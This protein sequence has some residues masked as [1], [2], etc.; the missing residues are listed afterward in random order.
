MAH[1]GIVDYEKFYR[2]NKPAYRSSAGDLINFSYDSAPIDDSKKLD[3]FGMGDLRLYF[4]DNNA[5]NYSVQE[6]YVRY[7]GG[8]YKL[9][10]GRKILD[11]NENEKYW[12]LGYLNGNQAFTLLSNEEE[13][14]TGIL[15]NTEFKPFE[16]DFLFSYTFIPQLNPSIDFQKG[17]VRSKS[18]WVRLPPQKTII[19]GTEVPIYYKVKNYNIAKI[20]FNKSLGGNLRY[21]WGKGGVSAFA[22]YKPENRLRANAEAYY[23]NIVLNKVVVEADPT[24]N[25]HAYYGIQV[26]QA[27]GDLK[28]KAGLS[29]VD[30]NAHIGKD[31]PIDIT[32]AR[33]TFKSPYFSINP[34]YEKEAYS[35]FSAN[36]GRN[37]YILSLNYI[38]II[39]KNIRTNDDF[40]S[41]TVK[42]KRAFGGGF[43]YFITDSFSVLF[44]LK[45]DLARFDNI[46]KSELKYNYKNKVNVSL[47]LEVLK[48]PDDNS[49]WSYY[50]ANDT[51]YSSIGLF[52]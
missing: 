9:F 50:R 7:K 42:W 23:D 40:S 30:P 31:F 13:G 21:T 39:S 37:N 43:T 27:F 48:A 22:I 18:D 6:A 14:L 34:S 26:F 10:I 1:V 16:F 28:T 32:N 24:V 11:W 46:V 17:E 44:D 4:Q 47:G 25:H 20:I 29:F 33:K 5:L 19:S 15:L 51:L 8:N 41:D 45:Y 36:L 3:V 2:L 52:F 49:Y 12:S 38:H 35:H